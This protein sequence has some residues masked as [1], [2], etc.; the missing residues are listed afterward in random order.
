M[1][2]CIATPLNDAPY[3]PTAVQQGHRTGPGVNDDPIPEFALRFRIA[4]SSEHA[5]VLESHGV[6]C[7]TSVS[8][9][10]RLLSSEGKRRARYNG[11]NQ[12][13]SAQ[14]RHKM[15]LTIADPLCRGRRVRAS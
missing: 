5:V 1:I 9:A 4:I 12:T 6:F 10:G 2:V 3:D 7:C 15:S 11:H 8:A 13:D 14:D